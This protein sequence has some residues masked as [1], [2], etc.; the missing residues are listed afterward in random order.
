MLRGI[1]IFAV[2]AIVGV[3]FG[4]PKGITQPSDVLLEEG[5]K[6]P[7]QT[8]GPIAWQAVRSDANGE[9]LQDRC[10][11]APDFNWAITIQLFLGFTGFGFAYIDQWGLFTLTM[12]SV[13]P[14]CLLVALYFL[15]KTYTFKDTHEGGYGVERKVVGEQTGWTPFVIG[16]V[17]CG[18][19]FLL[20]TLGLWL[21]GICAIASGSLHA[22]DGCPL[23]NQ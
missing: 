18:S 20:F 23:T 9:P 11:D 21:F 13:I 17:V 6:T 12:F 1:G 8:V 16:L 7:A 10:K 19:C 5:S 3:A 14:M 22:G 15:S 4:L 2:L